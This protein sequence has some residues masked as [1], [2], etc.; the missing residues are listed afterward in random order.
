MKKLMLSLAAATAIFV[1]MPKAAE[2]HTHISIGLGFL[3]GGYY[4]PRY[5]P[6]YAPVYHAPPPVYGY[7]AYYGRPVHY[8]YDRP[9]TYRP[10][11]YR[12]GPRYYYAR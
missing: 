7:P 4:E 9:V 2:A 5:E 11:A 6:R 1:G 8:V 12:P 3:R 10:V